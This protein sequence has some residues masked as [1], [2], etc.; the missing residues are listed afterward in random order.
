MKPDEAVKMLDRMRLES[1]SAEATYKPPRR[2]LDDYGRGEGPP[3]QAVSAADTGRMRDEQEAL[4]A[5]MNALRTLAAERAAREAAERGLKT[6]HESLAKFE[7]AAAESGA[8]LEAVAA[9]LK[10]EPVSDFMESFPVVAEARLTREAINAAADVAQERDDLRVAARKASEEADALAK[11]LDETRE[12]F[13]GAVRQRNEA[14]AKALEEAARLC[15]EAADADVAIYDGARL[16][17]QTGP[18]AIGTKIRALSSAPSEPATAPAEPVRTCAT[19]RSWVPDPESRRTVN[20]G[21]H[22]SGQCERHPSPF[23]HY[24]DEACPDW[25]ARESEASHE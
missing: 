17:W 11:E 22:P 13:L 16:L 12:D 20:D 25:A 19:C 4:F 5:G 3:P 24:S 23:A 1:T 9:A 7:N 10:G 14:R 21:G 6:A 18:R 8:L 2:A 15:D